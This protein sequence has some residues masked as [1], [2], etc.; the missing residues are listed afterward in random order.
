MNGT[1][2]LHLAL[3]ACGVGPGDEVIVPDL[4]FIATASTVIHAGAKPIFVDVNKDTWCIND[5]DIEPAIT[6]K[7]KAI[8]PVHLYGHPANMDRILEIAKKYNLIVIED[9]AESHGAEFNKKLTGTI[10]DVGVFS[11]Y[12]NKVITTGEGGMIVTDDDLIAK[13]ARQLRDHGMDRSKGY[14]HPELGFN[15]RM[16]SLQAALGV[17]QME[18]IDEV[19]EKKLQIAKTYEH[20]LSKSIGLILPKQASR[21]KHIYWMYTI[22]VEE[23]VTNINRD[24]MLKILKNEKIDAR[25][26]FIPMS[27]QPPF[28]TEKKFPV[29]NMLSSKGLSLPSYVGL[30]EDDIKRVCDV[31]NTAICI[32][33]KILRS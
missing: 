22:L 23:D 17:A 7:T 6:S 32:H 21:A 14:W 19:L 33:S 10:G 16:T 28:K 30:A 2:A 12:G 31:I 13:R 24:D 9:A 20:F 25:P 3:V 26:S 1:A 29:S 5:K 4:T 8:I 15:Y 11:F 18:K 27:C